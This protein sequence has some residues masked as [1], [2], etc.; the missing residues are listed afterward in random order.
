MSK[1]FNISTEEKQ[2]IL[3]LHEHANKEQNLKS[4]FS[5]QMDSRMPGQIETFGYKQGDPS[6]IKPALNQ[7]KEFLSQLSKISLSDKLSLPLHLRALLQYLLGRETPFTETEL[8]TKEKEFLKSVAIPN[9]SKGLTYPLWK[10]VGA[11]DLPTALSAGGSQKEKERLSKSGQG[12]MVTP[13]LA[14][15]FMYTLGEI[16]PPNIKVGPNKETVTVFDRYDMNLRDKSTNELIKSLTDQ[17]YNLVKGDATLYSVIRNLMTFRELSG[18]KGFPIK[19][20][21]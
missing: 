17:I 11:G 18:Y 9:A 8:T 20:T 12:N 3:N 1:I 2:R 15:Q 19:F 4:R 13:E 14:G 10:A 16:S 21:V 7:Q 5:E 6:T